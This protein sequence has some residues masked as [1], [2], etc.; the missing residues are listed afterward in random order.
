MVRCAKL[1][2]RP[3]RAAS[4]CVRLKLL[5]HHLKRLF[6]AVIIASLS[7]FGAAQ[8]ALSVGTSSGSAQLRVAAC[9]GS[10]IAFPFAS[11]FI[12]YLFGQPGM[13]P[14]NSPTGFH[15]GVDVW[16]SGGGGTDVY[17]PISGTVERVQPSGKGF[18]ISGA[19]FSIYLTHVENRQVNNGQSVVQ[20]STLLGQVDSGE[21]HIH[22][23]VGPTGFMDF[24][25]PVDPSDY[26]AAELSWG[27]W[28]A[29]NR[30]KALT[31]WCRQATTPPSGGNG[32][33][34][35]V[36]NLGAWCQHL[37]HKGVTTI[38]NNAYGLMCVTQSNGTVPMSVWDACKYQFNN[39]NAVDIM[40]DFNNPYDWKCYDTGSF[41]GAP[42]LG[43]WC[44]HL[45]HKGVIEVEDTAYGLRCLTQS[46]SFVH[47]SVFEACKWQFNRQ[48][49]IDSMRDFYNP[50]DWKCWSVN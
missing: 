20:G 30:S 49:V 12:G 43:A 36:P 33:A 9:P 6:P 24:G 21:R 19:T 8:L 14:V 11:G 44:Q 40:R 7:L 32:Q 48:D 45:G 31:D 1:P 41:L 13:N 37:G 25:S 10:S 50:Q 34:L 26:F 23:S 46:N 38:Q 47:M 4:P 35:G 2:S 42:N 15:Q 27:Y 28:G 5:A 29:E 17:A 16:P 22:I 18:Y 39:S 3:S